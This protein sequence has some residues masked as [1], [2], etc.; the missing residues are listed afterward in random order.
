MV[1]VEA[2]YPVIEWHQKGLVP[3]GKTLTDDPRC[4]YYNADFFEL[5]RTSGFDAERQCHQFDAILLD[6]DHTPGELLNPSH[7]DFYTPEGIR[8]LSEFI[9]PGGVFAL[10]SNEA[11]DDEFMHI[12]S[13]GFADVEGH[14]VEFANPVQGGTAINGVYV[15]RKI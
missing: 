4:V 2:L 5:A 13:A 9:K 6:I 11:P 15:A 12:L 1:V 3:N 10:W 14:T 8:R 7:A